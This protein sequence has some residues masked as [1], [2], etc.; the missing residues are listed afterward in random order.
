V[1]RRSLASCLCLVA[2]AWPVWVSAVQVELPHKGQF[3][4]WFDDAQGR[5]LGTKHLIKG[6]SRADVPIPA[7]SPK[8]LVARDVERNNLALI[9]FSGKPAIVK[10]EDFKYA[11][12]VKVTVEHR[13]KAVASAVVILKDAAG[14]KRELLSPDMKGVVVFHRVRLG[15]VSAQV[16]YRVKGEERKSGKLTLDLTADRS[17]PVPVLA[18]SIPDEVSIVGEERSEP[19]A[20]TGTAAK[21]TGGFPIGA[22]VTYA[23]A[24]GVGVGALYGLFRFVQ[25]R[26]KRMREMMQRLGVQPPSDVGDAQNVGAPHTSGFRSEPPPKAPLV[27]EGACPFCGQQKAQDGSCGCALGPTPA[28]AGPSGQPQLLVMTGP[29]A[30][31]VFPLTAPELVV[32]RDPACDISLAEDSSVSRRHAKLTLEGSDLWIEDLGSTNGT[33]VNGVKIDSRT[34]VS[35]G[36]TLQIGECRMRYAG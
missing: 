31:K 14:E 34:K 23:L 28:A 2:V 17:D 22:I 20:A 24:L 19:G 26:E 33:Y 30:A 25:A 13:G 7:G 9:P 10:L 27:P 36:D 16:E 6:Q 18:F 21:P 4:I 15:E 1:I 3:E 5:P 11:A 32:G 35:H 8:T 29:C 12:E